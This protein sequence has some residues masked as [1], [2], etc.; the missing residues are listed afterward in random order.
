MM[1]VPTELGG[2][3]VTLRDNSSIGLMK[4]RSSTF[5]QNVILLKKLVSIFTTVGEFPKMT[6]DLKLL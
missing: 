5:R 6:L 3:V 4:L 1:S 2:R